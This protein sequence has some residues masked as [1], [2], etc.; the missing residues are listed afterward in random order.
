MISLTEV[1]DTLGRVYDPPPPP[2]DPFR[3]V[4]WDNAGYLVDDQRRR[5]LYDRLAAEI[6]LNPL[7]IATADDAALISIAVEGGMHPDV[8]VGRWRAIAALTL[9][10]ASGDLDTALRVLPLAKARALLKRFPTIADPAADK[11]LLF[12]G[13]AALPALES[14]GLRALARL[15]LFV[16]GRSYDQSYRA[17][18]AALKA[19]GPND[20]ESLRRAYL[21]LRDHGKTLCRRNTPECAPCPLSDGCPRAVVSF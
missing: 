2:A 9:E 1:L 19:Q 8:R 18:I 16:E 15:G 13:I 7:A 6:G 14:N 5:R 12:A 21:V 20:V 3:H 11:I 10:L 4:L 17:G